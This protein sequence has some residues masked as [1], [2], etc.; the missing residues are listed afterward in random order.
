MPT[1]V[2]GIFADSNEDEMP[3][4][5]EELTVGYE[6]PPAIYELN[7]SLVAKYLGA[8]DSAGDDSVPPLAVAA[9]ALAALAEWLHLPPGTIHAS[10]DFEFF[11]LM[12]VGATVHCQAKVGRKLTRGSMRMLVLELSVADRSGQKVQSGKATIILPA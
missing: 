4:T 9:R 5:Y 7:A 1:R 8:V 11:K 3:V 12:P 2:G 10:Q 6:F